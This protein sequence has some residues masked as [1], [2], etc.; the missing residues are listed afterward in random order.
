[1][2]A[3]GFTAGRERYYRR[4]IALG[5][6]A[7]GIEP[8]VSSAVPGVPPGVW[9]GQAARVLGLSGVVSDEQMKALFGLGMHPDAKVL[10][11]RELERGASLKRAMKAAKL[12]PAVP[13][14][15]ELSSL[16]REVQQVLDQVGEQLCRP[17]TKAEMRQVRQRTAA[18]AFQ[19]EYH[20]PPADGAEL[21]RFLAAR[22]GPQRRAITGYDLTFSS[23]ELSLLFALGGPGVRRVVL[24]V[25]AQAR[26]ETVAWL[27][28]HAL[29]VR[30]G[31]GGVAQQ[32]AVPG[33]LGTV[34]LH[35]ESRAGDPMLHEHVVISPRVQGPDGRWRNL[36]S[37]LLL[38]E[39]VAASELFNQ[40]ALELICDRLALATE[41]VEVTCGQR[42]VMRIVGIDP[43]LRAAFAQRADAVRSMSESL[44]DDYRRR[45]GRQPQRPA[46]VRLRWQATVMTRPPKRAA[47]SLNELLAAWRRRAIA[48]TDR[49]VVDQLLATAQAAARNGPAPAAFDRR[50]C[51]EPGGRLNPCGRGPAPK[52]RSA[53]V[54]GIDTL[55][56]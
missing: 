30:T 18:H 23:E 35:Y 56:G 27:E 38:R 36:D 51:G 29:A 41:E 37:R 10:V 28:Q 42:P 32:Q 22:S 7:R 49:T 11:A 16:D 2:T 50:N 3:T 39:V 9:H 1:M 21:G 34:Y 19:A 26:S 17:L 8:T 33:L 55:T 13:R 14:L 4:D 46:R 25:L 45:H 12:G 52:M 44:F 31:P 24:E 5:D 40:R 20:R 54:A 47:R 53:I 48:V 43:R 6:G 15:T